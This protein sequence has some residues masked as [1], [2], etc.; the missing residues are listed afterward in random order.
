[1]RALDLRDKETEEHTL[2]VTDMAMMLAQ[3]LGLN[4][5]ELKYMRWGGLLHDIGKMAVLDKILLIPDALTPEEVD[6]MKQHPSYALQMLS[7]IH[8]LKLALDIPYCHHEHWDGSGYPRG[9]KAEEIPLAA[10]IFAIADVYD[11][12]SPDRPY[13]PKWD[14]LDVMK[15]IH[16]HGGSFFDP[17]IVSFFLQMIEENPSIGAAD[18]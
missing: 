15:Y 7:P 17:Q 4:D 1:L 12:L 16:D 3:R 14:E 8:Y 6:V 5:K 2:R 10:R 18:S 13:R 9:L 11:A